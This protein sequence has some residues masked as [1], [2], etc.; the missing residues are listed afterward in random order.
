MSY[1]GGG[2]D[3]DSFTMMR[4]GRGRFFGSDT[5][6]ILTRHD[7]DTWVE[8][9]RFG[10]EVSAGVALDE[11]V[12]SGAHPDTLRIV[13]VPTGFQRKLNRFAIAGLLL[14]M[15]ATVAIVALNLFD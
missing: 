9:G 7:G 3:P 11:A 6:S 15:I 8:I 1:G 10:D 4:V 2:P 12:A 14:V 5:V 13:T